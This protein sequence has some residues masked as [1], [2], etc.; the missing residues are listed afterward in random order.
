MSRQFVPG[1]EYDFQVIHAAIDARGK[2]GP[3][4]V[5]PRGLALRVPQEPVLGGPSFSERAALEWPGAVPE[6]AVGNG[7]RI[8]VFVDV[9]EARARFIGEGR[10]TR[11]SSGKGAP[12]DVRFTLTPTLS[13]TAWLELNSRNLPP[14]GP[15]PEEPLAGLN[16]ESG[17]GERWAALSSF[18][19]RWYGKTLSK[20]PATSTKTKA[21]PLLQKMLAVHSLIPEIVEHNEL[22]TADDLAEEDGKVVFLVENQAVCLWATEPEGADPRVWYRNNT[23]GEPWLEETE[24]LSGFLIQTSLFEA[25]LHARFG[26][27]AT[28]LP[29]D[30]VQPI[31]ER[32]TPLGR[33]RWNW[34]GARFFGG[35]GALVMTM[36][37]GD[38]T[39]VWLAAP[40][41]LALT[42]FEALVT[43]TWDRI[44]F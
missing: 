19:E 27:S 38:G 2:K 44:A 40:T 4:L 17:P 9:S 41:P 28:A 14:L 39:D 25:I 33:G 24:R 11:Y 21:P 15:P 35:G 18:L 37:N 6:R 5:G 7:A 22:V 34:G 42:P 31:L 1:E 13:R 32:V 3:F 26:A 23:E 30:A 10:A 36:E 16:A 20:L 29:P 8:L 12:R 43:D